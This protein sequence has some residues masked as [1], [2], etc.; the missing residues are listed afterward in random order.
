MLR[1]YTEDQKVTLS[2]TEDFFNSHWISTFSNTIYGRVKIISF[3]QKCFSY[4]YVNIL[5]TYLQKSD[6]TLTMPG[7]EIKPSKWLSFDLKELWQ[8]RE[9]FWFMAWRDIKV[10]YKQTLLGFIWVILQPLVL[11]LIFSTLWTQGN[12]SRNVD[13]PY[14]CLH[15]R[16]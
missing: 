9:L 2:S 12:E 5:L 11:M 6:W 15:I 3:S 7:Y 8:Y 1:N 16:A 13:M 14:P 4:F 10:K